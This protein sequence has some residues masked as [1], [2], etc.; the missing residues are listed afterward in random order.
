MWF[1]WTGG[2]I[3]TSTGTGGVASVIPLL[4][5]GRGED[6]TNEDMNY[7][8]GISTTGTATPNVLAADFEDTRASGNNHPLYGSTTVTAN[9][10]HHA[11]ATYDGVD[12]K[13]YLDGALDGQVSGGAQTPRSD[14]IQHAGSVPR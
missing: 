11:A 7:F 13:V 4:S 1:K 9:V 5:K 6:G 12:W 2:G 14:S 3:T 8:L 10:W